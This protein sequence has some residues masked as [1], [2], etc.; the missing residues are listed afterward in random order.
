MKA[1][2]LKLKYL[3]INNIGELDFHGEDFTP[4]H[5][6]MMFSDRSFQD[7]ILNNYYNGTSVIETYE[8]LA[9]GFITN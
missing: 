3:F 6:E 2:I 8:E 9:E 1:Y 5:I 4:L 7:V